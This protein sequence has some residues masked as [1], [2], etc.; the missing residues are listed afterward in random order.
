MN[1]GEDIY[2]TSDELLKRLK[3]HEAKIIKQAEKQNEE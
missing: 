3:K 1:K 2:L